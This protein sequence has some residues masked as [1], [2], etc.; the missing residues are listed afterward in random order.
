MNLKQ[1]KFN[2][3]QS[4]NYY[5]NNN[6]VVDDLDSS[7]NI[8]TSSPITVGSNSAAIFHFDDILLNHSNSSSL[9]QL[10]PSN[11]NYSKIN[12]QQIIHSSINHPISTQIQSIIT[13]SDYHQMQKLTMVHNHNHLKI[14][15]KS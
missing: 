8:A 5:N 2:Q 13:D 1:K 15:E 6:H 12:S 4:T 11:L 10:L 3:I 7:W 9:L 14:D